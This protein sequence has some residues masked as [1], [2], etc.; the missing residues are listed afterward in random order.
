MGSH[1]TSVSAKI[2][3]FDIEENLLKELEISGHFEENV[4]SNVYSY[5]FGNNFN[6]SIQERK[7]DKSKL[8]E[9]FDANSTCAGTELNSTLKRK[10]RKDFDSR[11]SR[12][13][14][15]NNRTPLSASPICN[16]RGSDDEG[17][18]HDESN[19]EIGDRDYDGLDCNY[20]C[21]DDDPEEMLDN[22]IEDDDSQNESAPTAPT[23]DDG[24]QNYAMENLEDIKKLPIKDLIYKLFLNIYNNEEENIQKLKNEIF[25][26]ITEQT[27]L[28][29]HINNAISKCMDHVKDELQSYI[30]KNLKSQKKK[31]MINDLPFIPFT[32][33]Q[34]SYNEIIDKII[35]FYEL[36]KSSITNIVEVWRE[37][38]N[39]IE[40]LYD[41]FEYRHKRLFSLNIWQDKEIMD[42]MR[43]Y[44]DQSTSYDNISKSIKFYKH[45]FIS[46]VKS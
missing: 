37:K 5:Y 40:K 24:D 26:K 20:S 3:Y 4:G 35:D 17:R 11:N 16:K 29:S 39:H 30:K 2:N 23:Y 38:L 14:N 32:D 12:K 33:N 6:K 18:N 22:D 1:Q 19:D 27:H 10:T 21:E 41:I 42:T 15:Y 46:S 43:L 9:F 45:L 13:H 7:D 28:D 44:F 34:Q 25:P 8:K 36:F 31:S